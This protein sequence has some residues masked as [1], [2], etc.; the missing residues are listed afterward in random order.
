MH[1]QVRVAVARL[2]AAGHAAVARHCG[3]EGLR[4][5]V[6]V[7][8]VGA[9][10]APRVDRG[11][12]GEGVA[13]DGRGAQAVGHGGEPPGLRQVAARPVEADLDVLL[14]VRLLAVLGQGRAAVGQLECPVAVEVAREEGAL[15]RVVL[16][17][18]GEGARGLERRAVG[19]QPEDFRARVLV[20]ELREAVVHVA[21]L[22]DHGVGAPVVVEVERQEGEAAVV[23]DRRVV[24]H[25]EVGR[26]GDGEGAVAVVA[27]HAQEALAPLVEDEVGQPVAVDVALLHAPAVADGGAVGHVA[28][29]E[30]SGGVR[31]ALV[32]VDPVAAV[33]EQ[34]EVREAVVV[35]VAREHPLDVLRHARGQGQ[36]HLADA[37]QA[38]ALV[39]HDDARVTAAHL[40]RAHAGDLVPAVAV[41][42]EGG[43]KRLGV[44]G[45]QADVLAL[46]LAALGG[47]H[48][49]APDDVE[50]GLVPGG[51]LVL[52]GV[53]GAAEGEE[54][55][56]QPVAVEV[57]DRR[58]GQQAP[59]G[60]GREAGRE[61]VDEGRVVI[62]DLARGL[63][64]AAADVDAGEERVL[65]QGCAGDAGRR[66]A[67]DVA[68][69]VAVEV[70]GEE[71]RVLL[72]DRLVHVLAW[73][74][75]R[76]GR[77]LEGRQGLPR[78]PHGREF[79]AAPVGLLHP[80]EACPLAGRPVEG[81]VIGERVGA[82]DGVVQ[83]RG[84]GG[85]ALV[86]PSTP[87]AQGE[88]AGAH[89]QAAV[90]EGDLAGEAASLGLV[91]AV[92]DGHGTD[93]EARELVG[94]G[95][96]VG[97][98]VRALG[99][100]PGGHMRLAAPVGV[101]LARAVGAPVLA[102]HARGCDDREP[103]VVAVGRHARVGVALHHIGGAVVAA[104]ARDGHEPLA[105][106]VEVVG[107]RVGHA[108]LLTV[109]EQV[110][111]PTRDGGQ[112]REPDAVARQAVAALL[113]VVGEG[114]VGRQRAAVGR[115]DVQG[116]VGRTRLAHGDG[117]RGRA[118]GAFPVERLEGE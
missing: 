13:D 43:E 81:V 36:A 73:H 87:V 65:I 68:H 10:C 49:G 17:R 41:Q 109:V 20:V 116:V 31:A 108:P 30:A 33:V 58:A 22:A 1:A 84:D 14:V 94:V 66:H 90:G 83:R 40:A 27:R 52:A 7:D 75:Q 89:A 8:G 118:H 106:E 99:D 5:G 62:S 103:P 71:A 113:A 88:G 60:E 64:A 86:V 55:V 104:C 47:G 79:L 21:G 35:E 101:G 32:E 42:V 28:V 69:T 54:E 93:A 4:Q 37:A 15:Q 70:G 23:L 16:A 117:T 48:V 92:G 96:G 24:G 57:H 111:A 110:G 77:G 45:V 3:H 39:L 19:Q 59:D 100:V 18:L 105:V 61:V 67:D 102:G 9:A 115:L 46:R 2:L 26:P 50:H 98:A 6:G 95:D 107:G 34:D 25:A 114:Q 74:P 82:V 97:V 51:R 38:A 56:V 63:H 85:E 29:V 80:D 112:A 53:A 72:G 76:R 44:H 78:E 11:A 91:G 12:G